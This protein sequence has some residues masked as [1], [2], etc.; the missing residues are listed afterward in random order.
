MPGVPGSQKRDSETSGA[1]AAGNG[2]ALCGCYEQSPGPLQSSAEPSLQSHDPA[3]VLLGT[4]L[5]VQKSACKDTC[6]LGCLL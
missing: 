2:D 3:V 1:R 6:A 5:M 4:D